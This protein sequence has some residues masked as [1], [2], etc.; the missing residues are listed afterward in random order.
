MGGKV[1]ETLCSSPILTAVFGGDELRLLASCGRVREYKP[2][3]TIARPEDE[4]VFVLHSGRVSLLLRVFSDG[5]RCGGEAEVE[6]DKP[7]EVFGWG[8]WVKPERISTA[9][10]ALDAVS[11]AALDLKRLHV[12]E[13]NWR[14]RSRML[15]ILYGWL[16]ECG[17]CP[18]NISAL[19][20]LGHVL[21]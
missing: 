4:R 6:L 9:A 3:E 15:Q 12:P 16:Q 1:I 11:V 5:G 18:P 21:A 14:L 13:L 2:G 10:S 8:A 17:L 7:G 20:G 19:L